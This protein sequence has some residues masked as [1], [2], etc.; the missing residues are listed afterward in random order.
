MAG[1]NKLDELLEWCVAL[2]F[3]AITLWVLSTENLKRPRE[4]VTGILSAVGE[5]LTLLANDHQIHNE[6][7]RVR[8]VGRLELLPQST[9]TAIRAAAEATRDYDGM[10]LTIAAAYGGLGGD[11]RCHAINASRTACPE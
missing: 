5:K 11:C 4:E 8:A 10:Q 3:S 9:L 2:R 1:A 7:I 6:R